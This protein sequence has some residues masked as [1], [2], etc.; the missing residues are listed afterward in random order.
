MSRT[1]RYLLN[2]FKQ[3]RNIFDKSFRKAKCKFEWDTR[4]NIE[5]LNT[6]NPWEFWGALKN[7]GPR[8]TNNIP[9]QVYDDE[10][11][12]TGEIDEVMAKWIFDFNHLFQG[13]DTNEFN[14]QF[15]NY[16]LNEKERLEAESNN[17]NT[18]IFN[19][20]L[21]LEEIQK[22]IDRP[23]NNKSV[24]IDNLPNEI[25]NDNMSSQLLL[26]LFNKIFVLHIIPSIWKKAMIKPI[27]KSSTIDPR[28]PLNYWGIALLST[29]Y[30]LYTLVLNNRLVSFLEINGIYAEEQNG[31]SSEHIFSVCTILKNR[32]SQ[33]KS[34]YLAFLDVEKAFDL[35][36][37]FTTL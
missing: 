3:N 35:V 26:S 30:K 6:E 36:D 4:I 20:V 8:K 25:F 11:N 10:G 24:G 13:Y 27:P 23:K 18:D 15:Y 7:F 22:V 34:I 16:I 19:S 5:R 37:R 2:K 1:R 14:P 17:G 28:L 29:V 31:F 9:M 12:I 32:K 33:K 21:S